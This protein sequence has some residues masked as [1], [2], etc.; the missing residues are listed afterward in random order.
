MLT[1]NFAQVLQNDTLRHVSGANVQVPVKWREFK[2]GKNAKQLCSDAGLEVDD[3]IEVESY[4]TIKKIV[5]YGSSS[6]VFKAHMHEK[7]EAARAEN[8]VIEIFGEDSQE[9]VVNECDDPG[10][11]V[12]AVKKVKNI[13][14]K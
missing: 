7:E 11:T 4:F 8:S 10:Y 5:G 6:T 3:S 9:P 12:V 2:T 13:F 14:D 1:K